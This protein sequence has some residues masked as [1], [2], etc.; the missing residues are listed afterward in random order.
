MKTIK[1]VK[2]NIDNILDEL[3]NIQRLAP[4]VFMIKRGDFIIRV[5]P[6]W[7]YNNPM[8]LS[9][10]RDKKMVVMQRANIAG[11]PVFY[12]VL[13]D[14]NDHLE[15]A[16]YIAVAESSELLREKKDGEEL[17][18]FGRWQT[19]RPI[20]A[21]TFISDE[22]YP[23]IKD[24][25]IGKFREAY[26]KKSALSEEQKMLMRELN[27]EFTKQVPR[28]AESEYYT[29][30]MLC[31]KLMYERTIEGQSIDAIVYPSV[32][33]QGQAGLNIAI[34]P[35]VADNSLM[36]DRVLEAKLHVKGMNAYL[37]NCKCMDG[38]FNK[39]C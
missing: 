4:V 11:N 21:L 29:T 37:E 16:R 33:T 30:A 28:G 23:S 15:N 17:F 35:D 39:V 3:L 9:Y 7:G 34:H 36:L 14:F 6:D 25:I 38:K 12:G 13:S 5:R 8:G 19:I 31:Y 18:T 24:S 26:L 22:T 10:P 2:Q 1:N 20:V 32:H 27:K